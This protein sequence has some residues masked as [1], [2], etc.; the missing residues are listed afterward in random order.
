MNR[1][2]RSRS[3]PVDEPD[4]ARTCAT[5]VGMAMSPEDETEDELTDGR[6]VCPTCGSESVIP[7]LYGR[8]TPALAALAVSG[9]VE[10][11]RGGAI[12]SRPTS[13]CRDCAHAWSRWARVPPER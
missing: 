1:P 10:I 2:G 5:L 3:D 12:G 7:I 9:A 11:G 13:R 8:G 6:L 4:L